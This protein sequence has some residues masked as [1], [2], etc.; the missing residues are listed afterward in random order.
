M[1]GRWT[2]RKFRGDPERRSRV[3]SAR[4]PGQA[5]RRP[6]SRFRWRAFSSHDSRNRP[7][8][9]R[10]RPGAGTLV[11]QVI[12]IRALQMICVFNR[13]ESPSCC[14]KRPRN[15]TCHGTRRVTLCLP[16]NALYDA[17]VRLQFD[18]NVRVDFRHCD[19]Q[20]ADLQAE[21]KRDERMT[22]QRSNGRIQGDFIRTLRFLI[23]VQSRVLPSWR[24]IAVVTRTVDAVPPTAEPARIPVQPRPVRIDDDV[25]PEHAGLGHGRSLRSSARLRKETDPGRRRACPGVGVFPLS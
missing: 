20:H 4:T 6:G 18:Q 24:R 3:P 17:Q 22:D 16:D 7:I 11:V 5:L 25:A 15:L 13:D 23:P 21:Q 1:I 2:I 10:P 9:E 19:A 12:V 8:P 14:P